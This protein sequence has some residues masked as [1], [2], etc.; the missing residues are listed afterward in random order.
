MENKTNKKSHSIIIG[1]ILCGKWGYSMDITSWYQVIKTT[2][3]KV[4]VREIASRIVEGNSMCGESVP[5]KF[6]FVKD[7]VLF[8]KVHN[9]GYTDY[10]DITDYQSAYKWDGKPKYHNHYD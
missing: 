1:D 7:D 5:V 9:N 4:Y 3:K 10:I 6:S 8:R 2:P